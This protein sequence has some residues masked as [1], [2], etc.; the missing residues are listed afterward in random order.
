MRRVGFREWVTLAASR[1]LQLARQALAVL[2]LFRAVVADVHPFIDFFRAQFLSPWIDLP[3]ALDGFDRIES[4]KYAELVTLA[5]RDQI[6]WI[7]FLTH[8]LPFIR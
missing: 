5:G 6:S 7:A 1:A 2:D 3:G 4:G 8:R